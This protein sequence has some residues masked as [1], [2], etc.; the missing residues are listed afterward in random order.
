V[1]CVTARYPLAARVGL[2]IVFSFP[3]ALFFGALGIRY[4]Q[5]RILA[6]ICTLIAGGLIIF[7]LWMIGFSIF[8]R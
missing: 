1:R 5:G 3:A 2:L 7:Y 8:C 4:D 6:L